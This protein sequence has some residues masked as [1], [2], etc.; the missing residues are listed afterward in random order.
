[1]S[2]V[3]S[4]RIIDFN[5]FDLL[6]IKLCAV[7]YRRIPNEPPILHKIE[8]CVYLSVND[9]RGPRVAQIK[10]L[11]RNPA[12]EFYIYIYRERERMFYARE[13]LNINIII[14]IY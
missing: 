8:D 6:V 14:M 11:W 4:S 10:K 5:Y 3:Q 1:M 12:G 2:Y 7:L 9:S 13:S